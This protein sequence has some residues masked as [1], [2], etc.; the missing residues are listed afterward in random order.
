MLK[1]NCSLFILMMLL[2]GTSEAQ[3]YGL[4]LGIILGEPTGISLK[5]WTSRTTAIDGAI[6]WSLG[7]HNRMYFHGDY[8]WHN[9]RIINVSKGRLPIYYGVGARLGFNGDSSLGIRGVIG[10]DYQ[11]AT[12]PL[13][14]FLELVPVMNLAPSTD[15]DFNGAI[16]VRYFF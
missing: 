11:F 1:R 13:D 4:G 7:K 12:I 9:D 5:Y 8:L 2:A 3:N 6:A 14:M 16:G 15:F 10:L